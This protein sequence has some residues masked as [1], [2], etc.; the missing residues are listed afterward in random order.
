M[1]K[2][3]ISHR[4]L[5]IEGALYTEITRT[6]KN[7]TIR[8]TLAEGNPREPWTLTSALSDG[9]SVLFA[10]S[11]MY[12]TQESAIDVADEHL[13]QANRIIVGNFSK[14]GG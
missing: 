10:Y 13:K 6:Y 2:G 4:P 5:E 12:E 1:E 7:Y 14:K 9:E 8:Q 11:G 3:K